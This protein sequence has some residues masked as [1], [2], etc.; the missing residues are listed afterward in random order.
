MHGVRSVSEDGADRDDA[1]ATAGESGPAPLE[2][3]PWGSNYVTLRNRWPRVAEAIAAAPLDEC[4]SISG[5]PFPALA[6]RGKQAVSAFDPLDEAHDQ[7]EDITGDAVYCY[8]VGMG[9]LPGVLAERHKH[10]YV[11]AMNLSIARAAFECTAMPWLLAPNVTM[12]L[13]SEVP[14]LYAPYACVGME[15]L[16][17]DEQGYALRDR[18]FADKNSRAMQ[19]LVLKPRE[20]QDARHAEENAKHVREDKHVNALFGAWAGKQVTIVGGG[21]TLMEEMGTVYD[22]TLVI[23][24]SSVLRTLLAGNAWF[25]RGIVPAVVVSVDTDPVNVCQLDGLD[26]ERTRNI[27]LVYHPQISPAFVAAWK[28]PR[29]FFANELFMG[30]TVMHVCADLAVQMGAS[31]VHM[32]GMDFCYPGRKSHAA[33]HQDQREVPLRPELRETVDGNGQRVYTSANL[34]QYHRFLENYIAKST[35]VRWVKHGRAGVSV[36]GAEWA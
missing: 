23:A 15:C 7:A 24:A 11:V 33:G 2:P 1:V 31:E 19:D 30:G 21:P 13:A 28:G 4:A 12:K 35:G 14:V 36:R 6:Y 16:L 27:A 18:I 32:V 26:M 22:S 20:A 3:S 5:T 17:A 10:V 34:A 25:P 9:H 29:Y 8:G